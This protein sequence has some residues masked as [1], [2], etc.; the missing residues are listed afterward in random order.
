[1]YAVVT[2]AKRRCVTVIAGVL[3][4]AKSHPASRGMP[5]HAIEEGVAKPQ[6]RLQSTPREA[7]AMSDERSR[8]ERYMRRCIELAHRAL[9]TG[10]PPVGAL[11]VIDERVVGEGVEGVKARRDVTA[12]AEIEALRSACERLGSVDLT[13]CTLY[14]SVEPCMMCAYAIR[15]ARIGVVVTGARSGGRGARDQRMDRALESRCASGQT[16]P[17]RDPRRDGARVCRGADGAFHRPRMTLAAAA[18]NS[19]SRG[20]GA[21][22]RRQPVPFR[23]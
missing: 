18:L 22:P 21:R 12:H 17:L 7:T 14:T 5:D 3:E 4:K 19:P 2:T 15:L 6:R 13:G 11:V 9:A 16:D 10:D 23:S 8:H 20:F 1:M